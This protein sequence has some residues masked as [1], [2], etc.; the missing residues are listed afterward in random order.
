M[1]GRMRARGKIV[2]YSEMFLFFI[3]I[4]KTDSME[5]ILFINYCMRAR[6]FEMCVHRSLETRIILFTVLLTF[7][8]TSFLLLPFWLWR[9]GATAPLIFWN[10][11]YRR[12]YIWKMMERCARA[13]E[14]IIRFHV[15]VLHV[16]TFI[17]RDVMWIDAIF[18]LRKYL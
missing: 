2:F 17:S 7:T 13:I 18:A 1:N 14:C 4:F 12:V 9:Y 8:R 16:S 15:G 6:A 5:A 11:E 3:Y 10:M